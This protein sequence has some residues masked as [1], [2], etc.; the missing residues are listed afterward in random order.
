MSDLHFDLYTSANAPCESNCNSIAT[1]ANAPRACEFLEENGITLLL[2]CRQ[3]SKVVLV[4]GASG[5]CT[6]K[7][8][9][10]P[11]PMGAHIR[12]G[13]LVLG[14][15]F[16][17][18]VFRDITPEDKENSTFFPTSFHSTGAV[19]IHDVSLDEDGDIWFV[20][21]AFSAISRTSSLNNFSLDWTPNFIEQFAPLDFCHLNGMASNK[22]TPAFATSLGTTGVPEGW[23]RTAPDGGALIDVRTRSVIID[24][25]SMPHSPIYDAGELWLLESGRGRLIHY[26]VDEDVKQI[27]TR[28]ARGVLRGL[29]MKDNHLLVG[30][31]PIRRS[32][33]SVSKVLSTR[34]RALEECEISIINRMDLRTFERIPL[35]G[36]TEISSLHI[37]PKPKA[38][39]LSPSATQSA[40]T[41]VASRKRRSGNYVG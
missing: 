1:I 14:T 15:A 9:R 23:R 5:H 16:G 30:S 31:S 41:F 17:V 18:M 35:P 10:V 8:V 11:S 12:E 25:L 37:I 38:S 34:L 33:G 3:D 27:K 24:N 6:L 19:S 22:G 20:N 32:S 26:S 28:E 13:T 39:L 4:S 7:S 40:A 21:T 2:T 36:V 29:A